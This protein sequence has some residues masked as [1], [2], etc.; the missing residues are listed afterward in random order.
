MPKSCPVKGCEKNC[1]TIEGLFEHLYMAHP[2]ADLV[3]TIIRMLERQR[4]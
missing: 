1:Q 3:A 2:K 4:T